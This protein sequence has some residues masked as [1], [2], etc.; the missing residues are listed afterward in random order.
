MVGDSAIMSLFVICN[1]PY[2]SGTDGAVYAAA[3]AERLLA[4]RKK[5]GDIPVG[6]AAAAP[7]F[8]LDAMKA[9]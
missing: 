9:S 5:I 2:A 1:I 8:S 4:E 7:A 3:G 6:Q